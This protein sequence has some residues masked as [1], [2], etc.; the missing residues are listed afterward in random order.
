MSQS[1][2]Y[3]KGYNRGSYTNYREQLHVDNVIMHI[4]HIPYQPNIILS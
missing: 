2:F 1:P 4:I 3:E